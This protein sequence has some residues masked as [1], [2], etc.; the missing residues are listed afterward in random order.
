VS[1]YKTYSEYE[2]SGVKWLGDVPKGWK[3]LRLG[4]YFVERRE[5]VSDK[6]YAPLSV[7]MKG[8][9]PQLENAAKSD[10]GDNRKLVRKD[11]F[12]INSRSDRKGSSGIS[13]LNGSVS[14][15]SI[16]ITPR[17]LFSTFVHHLFR[18][19]SFQE[20]FYRFGK[21]IVADLWSTNYSSMKNIIIPIPSPY[22]QQKI[23]SFL[24]YETGKLDELIA[25][26]Q[27]LIALLEEKRQAV[28]SYAVTKGLDSS[29]PM[30]PS[31]VEWIGEV[32]KHWNRGKFNLCVSIA[33]GQVDP[34]KP[35]YI[36]MLLI[37]PNHIESGT[38]K[39]I[40][41]E[42]AKEQGADSGKYWC[43]KGDIIY[44]KIRPA[45]KKVGIAPED[46]LCSA[47]MYPMKANQDMVNK[48]VYWF[49]LSE[50]FSTFA[51]LESDRVAMPKINRDSLGGCYLP[52][53]PSKEQQ[54][55]ANFLDNQTIKIGNL[56]G[57]ANSAI[58]LMRER[59][60]ALISAAVTGKI[61]VRDLNIGNENIYSEAG[62]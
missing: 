5:K 44:S 35:K 16:V 41:F 45:L 11:D 18:S 50:Q 7:T 58:A 10:A 51:I 33:N 15:I 27:E 53:P 19:Y 49:L 20:E 47:D 62:A 21:G 14:L 43:D 2:Y 52:I 3:T 26:Q 56:I 12:V 4:Q 60:T 38:G 61:D 46:C 8:I 37:A 9:V 28:I 57:K 31:G 54:Q 42:T 23:A 17:G 34:R 25:K 6:D 55:I 29:V 24:D 1:K 13:S 40:G 32:P 39:I 59:R 22:E 30:K 48:F 36:N